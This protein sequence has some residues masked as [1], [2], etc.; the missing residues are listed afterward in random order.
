MS[1][2][3]VKA[4][5]IDTSYLCKIVDFDNPDFRKL[6]R[7]SK[8]G[9][10]KIVI[11]HIVWEERRTQFLE[12]AYAKAQK[13]R[14]AFE[15]LKAPWT[16]KFIIDGLAPPTL[17]VWTDVEM[18]ARSKEMMAA[19]AAENNIE[20]VPLGADHA[21]R[22]WQRYFNV[23]PPFRREVVPRDHRRKDIPDS[24]IFEAAIDLVKKYPGLLA[25]CKDDNL[26]NNLA[27][28]GV[29]VFGETQE[30]LDEVEK[31]LTP[32]PKPAAEPAVTAGVDD[33]GAILAKAR[34]PFGE[35]E[36][37]IL[38]YVGFLKSPSKDQLFKLLSECGVPTELAK[39]VAERLVITG[40]ITDT[41][42]HYI[43]RDKKACD[44]AA[45]LVESEIIKLMQN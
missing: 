14:A 33:L 30:V 45:N 40:L 3:H 17:S 38:G 31:A 5:L 12:T 36:T 21:E 26:S 42:N 11:S 16:G 20:I 7:F 8:S 19:F 32:K 37:K 27:S 28:I 15:S 1:D 22:A 6:L 23:D 18:D 41:G 9:E 44:L 43:P 13:L 25:L 35:L 4:L 29:A 39:N 2:K 24:W 34:E 10:L